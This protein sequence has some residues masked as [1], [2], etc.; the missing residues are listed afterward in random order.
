MKLTK[1]V[2]DNFGDCIYCTCIIYLYCENEFLS[3]VVRFRMRSFTSASTRSAA[4]TKFS[5]RPK[6]ASRSVT[7]KLK[8]R[9]SR[10]VWPPM[11]SPIRRSRMLFSIKFRMQ[12]RSKLT[13]QLRNECKQ[14]REILLIV[15]CLILT[16]CCS[17]Q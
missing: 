6:A 15:E 12:G 2:K 5:L 17:I 8:Q 11:E 13:F 4:S 1:I 3:S 7:S 14:M 10:S 9:S 16:F